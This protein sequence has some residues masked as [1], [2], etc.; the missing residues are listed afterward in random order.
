MKSSR[1][2]LAG[3]G[4]L[5]LVALLALANGARAGEAYCDACKGDS[6]WSGAAKLDEIGN[7]NAH[8]HEEVMAG[9][10]T[11]QKN[12]VGIWKKP[13]AGFE[14]D[15]NPAAN[16]NN[17]TNTTP[18]AVKAITSESK[19]VV[20]DAPAVRSEQSRRMLVPVEGVSGTDVLLDISE[21][22]ENASEHIQ[23]SIAIPYNE[24]I[25]NNSF[26]SVAE[27]T[28]ILGAAGISE[29]DPLIVYGECMP[30]G[31]GPAPAD[32]IYLMLK[33]LGHENVRVLDGTV[34][35]WAAAGK[36]TS[37]EPAIRSPA[38]YAAQFTPDLLATYDY[39]KSGS[40]QILDARTMQEFGAG[41]I[42]G[43]M[44]NIPYESVLDGKRIKDEAK[45][46]RVFATLSKDRPVVVFTNTGLKAS[47]VWFALELMGYDARL[48]SYENWLA[49]QGAA[50]NKTA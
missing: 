39:V 26:K 47:V 29:K 6:G 3:L 4:V 25:R 8:N 21:K 10:N 19:P 1:F 50:E 33:S 36:P 15:P 40:A 32:Y 22:S 31:G 20:A 35:D 48:Y 13:A 9:L 34:E 12:R 2:W 41:S 30:C 17:V 37:Q 43:V 24:F 16:V 5:A 28:E 42:P 23:G 7:P 18:V 45:L 14:D 46:E 38:K 44:F 27:V 11:A 49:N